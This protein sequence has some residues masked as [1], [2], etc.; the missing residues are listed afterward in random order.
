[1]RSINDLDLGLLQVLHA[2]L[3]ENHLT[4]AATRVGLT[5][6]AMSHALGRLRRVLGDPL[7]VRARTGMVPTPR[8]L[9]LGERV[10]R[11]LRDA[12]SLV[13]DA[14]VVLPKDLRRGFTI[15]MADY[16]ETQVLPPLVKRLS[17]DAPGVDLASRPVPVDLEES[18]A[19]GRV[20]IA[21]GVFREL[22][23]RLYA[24]RMYQE[25]FVSAVR[26]GH[27][28]LKKRM[29]LDLFTSLNHVLIAPGGAPGGQV[30][31]A[32]AELGKQ[33]RVVA[34][35]GHF[36]VAPLLVSTGNLVLTAP[37][38]L[39]K[40]VAGFYKLKLFPTPLAIPDF[41]VQQVWHERA[42]K[43]ATHIWFRNVL[44]DV[45]K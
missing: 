10:E 44:M 34:R 29:N 17:V 43:D 15:A 31:V 40:S 1:M 22:S 8:A 42:Q 20:D 2:L 33:R 14:A 11:I 4:R 45:V 25:R 39:L 28:V 12:Q 41:A 5:Q 13:E 27:P 16:G 21:V 26:R 23:P 24:R 7:M 37:E 38:R 36:L 32:L 30:D 19:S 35:V 3:Q 18:M 6:P 9:A